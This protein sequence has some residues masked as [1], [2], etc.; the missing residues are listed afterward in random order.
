[1]DRTGV[2]RTIHG[3]R[4]ALADLLEALS[5]PTGTGR[6]C[7]RGGASARSPRT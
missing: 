5:R 6:R 4:A 7:A 3:E 2:W 1:M